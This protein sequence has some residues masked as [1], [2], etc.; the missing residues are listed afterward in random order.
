MA[1]EKEGRAQKGGLG[2][3]LDALWGENLSIEE[4]KQSKVQNVPINNI[5]PN[6]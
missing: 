3:G 1:K 4:E 2:R 5:D 6:P